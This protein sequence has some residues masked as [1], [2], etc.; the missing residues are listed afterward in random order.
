MGGEPRP[1]SRS[2]LCRSSRLRTAYLTPDRRELPGAL[3]FR[4]VSLLSHIPPPHLGQLTIS[5]SLTGEARTAVAVGAVPFVAPG[6]FP[7]ADATA[8]TGARL[9]VM[10]HVRDLRVFNWPG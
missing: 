2:G 5:M 1:T 8:A 6:L 9:T 7:L 3:D 10:A 4:L